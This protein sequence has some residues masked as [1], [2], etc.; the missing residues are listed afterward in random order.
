L[1]PLGILVG[2]HTF[3]VGADEPGGAF[4]GGAILAAM[5]MIVMIARVSEPPSVNSRWLRLALVAGPG[6]FLVAGL[7]GLGMAGNF[8]AYPDGFAKPIILF[9][10]AFMLLTIAATLPVLVAGPPRRRPEP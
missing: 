2:V 10:E 9:I 1:V 8:F 6:V 3:W 7:A 4:Q 5:W